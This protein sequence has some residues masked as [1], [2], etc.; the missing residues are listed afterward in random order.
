MQ[1]RPIFRQF[2]LA[3]RLQRREAASTNNEP[4][5]IQMNIKSTKNSLSV[6]TS[7]KAGGL[8]T[9]NHNRAAL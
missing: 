2:L 5:R 6:K 4:R 3:H 1:S 9:I 7:I 8:G